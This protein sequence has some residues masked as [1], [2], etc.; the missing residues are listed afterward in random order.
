MNALLATGQQMTG[1]IE[2]TFNA[3]IGKAIEDILLIFA[4][5]L[6]GELDGQIYYLP[7]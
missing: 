6:E 1:V 2:V 4:C 7:L 5:S 3:P